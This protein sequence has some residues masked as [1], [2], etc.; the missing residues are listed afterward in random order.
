M[1]LRNMKVY[2]TKVRIFIV[3]NFSDSNSPPLPLSL[4]GLSKENATS[5]PT[6]TT[7][8]DLP[9]PG[10]SRLSTSGGRGGGTNM[11][12]DKLTGDSLLFFSYSAAAGGGG[13]GGQNPDSQLGRFLEW[14][15]SS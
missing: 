12:L 2:R 15:T 6:Q 10:V 11:S 14:L 8:T 1:K 3:T 7:P 9:P 5:S 13:G 4:S